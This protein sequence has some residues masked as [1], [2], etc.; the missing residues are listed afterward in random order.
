M[1]MKRDLFE[2]S[3]K[4]KRTSP[5]NTVKDEQINN[6]LLLS[7][8]NERS[9]DGMLDELRKFQEDHGHARV[10]TKH[11]PNPAL[12]R[13]VDNQRQAYRRK[14]EGGQSWLTEDRIRLLEE[15]GFEWKVATYEFR[16]WN[17]WLEDLKEFHAHHGHCRVPHK[18]NIQDKYARLGR[19]VGNQRQQHREFMAGRKSQ[20]NKERIEA[21]DALGF[22]WDPDGSVP[23]LMFHERVEQLKKFRDKYGHMNVS[24]KDPEYAQL[25][26]WIH[27]M[28]GQY[29]NRKAG[30]PYR[31]RNEGKPSPMTDERLAALVMAGFEFERGNEVT[32]K[33]WLQKLKIYKEKHGHTWIKVNDPEH[34]QL[35]TWC[36]KQRGLYKQRQAG[37]N[38]RLTDERIT[39]LEELG[40]QWVRPSK[41][42]NSKKEM[43]DLEEEGIKDPTEE[44]G[45]AANWSRW[46]EKL[47]KY[48]EE[49]GHTRVNVKD[50]EY[51]GLGTWVSKQRVL[52]RQRLAG[53]NRRIT[54][55]RVNMLE[56]LNFDW[57]LSYGKQKKSS[58]KENME[59][60]P[61]PV[62]LQVV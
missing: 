46:Y 1:D 25:A 8:K 11:K 49:H 4:R 42:S 41:G 35:A 16:D 34:T 61:T 27:Q 22:E 32:W 50:A 24:E 30:K 33:G 37:M 23:K 39:A 44:K 53:K 60:H 6:N 7:S 56:K 18:T 59:E 45:F 13:W 54:D 15:I 36:R 43:D 62:S 55:E 5:T 14:K 20:I 19:W 9:W 58:Q 31:S 28:R 12:G 38:R 51:A 10:P 48:K 17:D 57:N 29:R 26:H 2:G 52:Y 40:F 21:L 3:N 47:R